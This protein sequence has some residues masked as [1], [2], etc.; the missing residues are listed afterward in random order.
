MEFEVPINGF[1]AETI[2]LAATFGI[3]PFPGKS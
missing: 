1:A 3:W 2:L